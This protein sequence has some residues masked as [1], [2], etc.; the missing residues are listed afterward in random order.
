MTRNIDIETSN[1]LKKNDEHKPKS[2]QV[3]Y[4]TIERERRI[5]DKGDS[6][7]HSTFFI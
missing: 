2:S 4:S 1:V 3:L 6:D 5:T 7:K